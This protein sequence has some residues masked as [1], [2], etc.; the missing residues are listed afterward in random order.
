MRLQATR[1]KRRKEERLSADM[2]ESLLTL[3]A[4]GLFMASITL[5]LFNI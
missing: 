4:I 3:F 5:M 1:K 2:I